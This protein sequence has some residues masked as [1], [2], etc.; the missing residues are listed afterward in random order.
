LG[1]WGAL[2]EKLPKDNLDNAV[3][4]AKVFL[5]NATNNIIR[6]DDCNKTVVVDGLNDYIIVDREDVLLIYPKR[7]EQD[8]K[9]ISKSVEDMI[10]KTKK[11]PD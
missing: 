4:N 7:K 3:V 8:I 2:Y 10:L 6:T 5:E 1:T 9:K 11:L